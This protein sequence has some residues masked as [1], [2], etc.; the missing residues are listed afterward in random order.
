VLRAAGKGAVEVGFQRVERGQAVARNLVAQGVGQ[1]REAVQ[2]QQ[3]AAQPARQQAQGDGEVLRARP[4][5]DDLG[6]QRGRG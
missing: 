3:V 5:E 2:G 1:A 6:G 4:A